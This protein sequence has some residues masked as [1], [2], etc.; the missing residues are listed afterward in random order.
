M[1]AHLNLVRQFHVGSRALREEVRFS[2]AM[3]VAR[4]DLG[5]HCIYLMKP[6]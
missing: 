1:T 4:G 6:Q 2:R 5:P 3:N